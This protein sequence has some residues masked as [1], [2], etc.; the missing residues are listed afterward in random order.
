MRNI[1]NPLF[2]PKEDPRTN[3]AFQKAMEAI[4]LNVASTTQ[5]NQQVKETTRM[6]IIR[7]PGVDIA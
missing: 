4:D 7:M 2:G 3:D 5:V 1:L 6:L